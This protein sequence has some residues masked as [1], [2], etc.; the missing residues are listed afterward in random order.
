MLLEG[1]LPVGVPRPIHIFMAQLW[2]L[3]FPPKRP[4]LATGQRSAPMSHRDQISVASCGQAGC[5]QPICRNAAK[6]II[7]K[8]RGLPRRCNR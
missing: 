3:Q 7:D 6:A 5:G 4:R 1:R 8:K 2:I